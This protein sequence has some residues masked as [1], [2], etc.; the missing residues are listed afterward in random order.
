VPGALHASDGPLTTRSCN[1]FEIYRRC[2]RKVHGS[3]AELKP[4]SE[5]RLTSYFDRLPEKQ[6]PF[7]EGVRLDDQGDVDVARVL[8]NVTATGAYKGAAA[9]ARSLE[10]LEDFL[11]FALFEVKNLLTGDQ[12]EAL[13]REVGRMQVGKA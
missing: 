9:K 13:L 11:A 7:F 8:A 2:L 10:A 4:G 3:L 6:R 5:L 12:A 1:P